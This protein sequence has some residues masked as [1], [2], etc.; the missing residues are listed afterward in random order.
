[1]ATTELHAIL[2][3][4]RRLK[5]TNQD[6]VL[7]TVVHVSGSAYR[8]PGARMLVVPGGDRVGSVSGGCLEG[9]IARRGWWFT[10]GGTPVVRSYD[11]TSDEDAV[12]DF[13]LGCNG[14]VQIMLERTSTTGATEMLD[15]LS[16]QRE[17][18]EPA[19]VATVIRTDE[20][21]SV[22][23]GDRLL[24]DEAC[25]C[26]GALVGS[27]LEDGVRQRSGEVLRSA[28][29]CLV[30]FHEAD[31]FIEW[32]GPPLSLFVFGAGD[33]AIPLVATARQL[34]WLVT[35]ADGRPAYARSERFPEANHVIVMAAGD[36]LREVDV[37]AA[38]AVVMMTH[39]Y[40]LDA[41]LL[42]LVLARRPRYLGLL[43]PR[44]RTEKLFA[45]LGLEIPAH[46]H[47]PVGLDI[48]GDTPAAAALSIAAEIHAATHRRVGGMLGLR[49][50][51]IHSPVVEVGAPGYRRPEAAARLLYC[52][53]L[54]G[55]HV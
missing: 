49:N 19:A 39:N 52:E 28:Q 17:S 14:I 47:A 21:S 32:I 37:D 18:G 48:G 6:A 33:D 41:R 31:V 15:F 30:H 13:G 34:G 26:R 2:D 51:G 43:G 27:T 45:G 20:G 8:H 29:S 5:R 10:G 9:E 24:L 40:P 11:T 42:P 7:A 54:A 53:T 16:A 38:A 46:V 22:R 36:P 4:W 44:S 12:W 3:T 25:V 55:S 23:V 50:E 1:M 35:V